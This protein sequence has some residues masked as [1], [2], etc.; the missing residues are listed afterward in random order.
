MKWTMWWLVALV[1]VGSCGSRVDP[2]NTPELP[3]TTPEMVLDMLAA[4]EQPVI[5]NVW[6]SWCI[7]C[8]SEA[9]LLRE[10]HA[11]FGDR[12]RFVGIDVED[13][14]DGARSFLAEFELDF[15]H[16]FDPSGSIPAA[17]GG[18]GVPITYFFA[19]TGELVERHNGVIDERTLSLQIDELLNR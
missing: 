3:P 4:S 13:S 18:V 15:E 5:V 8:R 10:A 2:G 6:A 7:P 19:P 12:V 14:Q 17:L 16:Y 11:R 1:L 9:P